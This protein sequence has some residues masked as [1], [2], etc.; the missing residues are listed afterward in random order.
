MYTELINSLM[1]ELLTC[2]IMNIYTSDDVKITIGI[3]GISKDQIEFKSFGIVINE[4]GKKVWYSYSN[5][6]KIEVY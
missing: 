3:S 2:N 5:I 1:I 6:H 4:P